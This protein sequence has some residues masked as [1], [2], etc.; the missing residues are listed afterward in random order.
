MRS[1]LLAVMLSGTTLPAL[2]QT[3]VP[4]TGISAIAGGGT[5]WDDEGRIG[6]GGLAA[7]H[8]DHRLAGNTYVDIGVEWLAHE[9]HDRF[10]AEG[11]SVIT[12]ASLLQRFGRR[13]AQPY[14]LGGLALVHHDGTFGFPEDGRLVDTNS[15]D[16]G[17]VFGGGLAVRLAARVEIGPEARFLITGSD[18]DS[19]PAYAQWIGARCRIGF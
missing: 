6:S 14:V 15:T 11:H 19:A 13:R 8:A 4:A 9:R 17:F 3:T 7:V 2:G 10:T 18:T 16:L 12:T 1:V 5:T